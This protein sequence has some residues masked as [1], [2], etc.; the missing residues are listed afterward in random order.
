[1][2]TN[3]SVEHAARRFVNGQG[4]ARTGHS[5][6]GPPFALKQSFHHLSATPSGVGGPHA[7]ATS[8][9]RLLLVVGRK[10]RGEM[11]RMLSAT[12]VPRFASGGFWQS[13]MTAVLAWEDSDEQRQRMVQT[14]FR[15]GRGCVGGEQWGCSPTT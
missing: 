14:R 2:R 13:S 15:Q 10:Q 3:V 6:I 8:R 5:I 7:L 4:S 12:D 1:M 11:R 9:S